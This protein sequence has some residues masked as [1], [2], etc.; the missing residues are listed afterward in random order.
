MGKAEPEQVEALRQALAQRRA[1]RIQA[2][3]DGEPLHVLQ[4]AVALVRRDRDAGTSTTLRRHRAL[5]EHLLGDVDDLVTLLA[6]VSIRLGVSGMPTDAPQRHSGL[7]AGQTGLTALLDLAT[8]LNEPPAPAG[9]CGSVTSTSTGRPC[10]APDTAATTTTP[11][12]DGAP[13]TAASTWT[14][15][16]GTAST[17]TPLTAGATKGSTA[18]AVSTADIDQPPPPRRWLAADTYPV[19][20][21]H[22]AATDNCADRNLAVDITAA[23]AEADR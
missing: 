6:R 4:E 13:P 14:T 21:A 16:T 20:G 7:T 9:S 2:E 11:P 19:T 18:T 8:A 23:A 12:T 3:H 1:D 17:G 22:P 10:S 5:F 15:S